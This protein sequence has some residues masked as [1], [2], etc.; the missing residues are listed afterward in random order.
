MSFSREKYISDLARRF[1]PYA[2][3]QWTDIPVPVVMAKACIRAVVTDAEVLE[4]TLDSTR[5]RGGLCSLHRDVRAPGCGICG[6][7]PGDIHGKARQGASAVGTA[8]ARLSVPETRR[9][10]ITYRKWGGDPALSFS[11]LYRP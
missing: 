4:C 7:L 6:A 1:D 10:A 5:Y 8:C 2:N 3:V 11:P 9:L